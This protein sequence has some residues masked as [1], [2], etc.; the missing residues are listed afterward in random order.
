[1]ERERVLTLN[2]RVLAKLGS[3]ALDPPICE[4]KAISLPMSF[5][6]SLLI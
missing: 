3:G 5:A 2:I 6:R 4:A 1:V